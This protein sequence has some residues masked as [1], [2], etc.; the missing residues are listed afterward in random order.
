M[1]DIIEQLYEINI[2][3]INKANNAYIIES[4]KQVYILK[5]VAKKIFEKNIKYLNNKYHKIILN[6]NRELI[7][8]VENNYYVLL[9]PVFISEEI[10][11][12]DFIF[13]D[14]TPDWDIKLWEN[15]SDAYK[16]YLSLNADIKR[17]IIVYLNYYL[18]ITEN[19]ITLYN[20]AINL[21]GMLRNVI[22]HNN[23]YQP[24]YGINYYDPTNVLIDSISRDLCEYA[25]K[26]NLSTDKMIDMFKEY[27]LSEKEI[28]IFLA[29]MLYP[30]RFYEW[31][32]NYLES[33]N[34]DGFRKVIE[35]TDKNIEQYKG[36]VKELKKSNLYL[37]EISW[38][39]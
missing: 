36:L 4:N 20:T 14:N 32:D 21:P 15:K 16:K 35:E 13:V 3:L 30:K 10:T 38:I 31:F 19:A 12:L 22:S 2:D 33:K 27:E 17:E 7:S 28:N 9:D 11:N 26:Y 29:R 6:R 23:I 24:N 34:T 39:L 25:K 8:K 18:G 37:D 5:V 1:K